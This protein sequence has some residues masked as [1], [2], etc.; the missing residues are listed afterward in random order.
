[1]GFPIAAILPIIGAALSAGGLGY[2]I[3]G[4]KKAEGEAEDWKEKEEARQ[5]YE[6]QKAKKAARQAALSRAVGGTLTTAPRFE[7]RAISPPTGLG[8]DAAIGGAVSALG[9]TM[10]S[11]PERYA[12]LLRKLG[13]LFGGGGGGD[14]GIGGYSGYS[15]PTSYSTSGMG[16]G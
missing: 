3:Y 7:S 5:A 8:S 4:Q 12:A 13:S 15:G 1:M 11:N 14:Y 10:L 2:N 9:S 16:I 6:A